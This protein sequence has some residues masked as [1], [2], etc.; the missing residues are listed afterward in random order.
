MSGIF[1]ILGLQDHD[2]A[3]LNTLGQQV[4]FDAANDEM[5]RQNEEIMSVLGVFVEAETESFKERYK[6]PA[7]GRLQRISGLTQTAAAKTYGKW[8]V[9]YPLEDFGAQ[10]AQDRI[11]FAYATAQDL[12]RHLDSVNMQNINTLRFELLYALFNSTAATFTDRNHGNLTVERLA[13]GDSVVYPPVLGSESEAT[14]NHY[15]E[16]G[17]AASAISD[18]NDPYVTIVDELEEHFGAPTGGSEI[19]IFVNNA[20]R[21]KTEAL[22]EF[23]QTSDRFIQEGSQTAIPLMPGQR[24]PGRTLGRHGAGA[25]VQEW[26]WIPSG[27]MLAIHLGAPKPLKI[28][29]HPASTG[30]PRSLQ[31]VSQSDIYP[32]TQSHYEHHFGFGVGNRLNGVVMEL[33]T[34]GTYSV[35]TAYQ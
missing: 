8:D 21:A 1:G 33:G 31:L 4:I 29:R 30:L 10:V 34:G 22:T 18:T 12:N 14:D 27:W 5:R 23:T 13:N 32:F 3:F 11:D 20:Q 9:A 7:G 16:S 35:P 25:W 17:Y 24:L 15:L 26:R 28:R 6:L 2:Y 19:V